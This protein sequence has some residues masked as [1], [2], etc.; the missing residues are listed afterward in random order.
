V[1]GPFKTLG[2]P[3]YTR[4]FFCISLIGC[5][6]RP[7]IWISFGLELRPVWE[8]DLA[9]SPSLRPYDCNL[10]T[11]S[12]STRARK[13]LR[14]RRRSLSTPPPSLRVAAA[15]AAADSGQ[16]CT[17]SAPPGEASGRRDTT[18]RLG[19]ISRTGRRVTAFQSL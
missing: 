5:T 15:R 18:R 14:L 7:A 16:W 19:P 8:Q 3:K 4:Q 10:W 11:G 2:L 9:R 1:L 12:Q 13:V 17:G 6:D